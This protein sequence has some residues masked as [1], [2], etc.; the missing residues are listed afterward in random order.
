MWQTGTYKGIKTKTLLQQKQEAEN[1]KTAYKGCPADTGLG[2]VR[3]AVRASGGE[4][5][6]TLD[7]YWIT[8]HTTQEN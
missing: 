2:R 6:L 1:D 5:K 7:D 3:T 4:G 8:P